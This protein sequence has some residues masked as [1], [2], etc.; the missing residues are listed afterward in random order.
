VAALTIGAACACGDGSGTSGTGGSSGAQPTPSGSTTGAAIDPSQYSRLVYVAA[1][2]SDANPGTIDRPWA[3]AQFAAESATPGTLVYFRAGTYRQGF[4]T[5]RGGSAGAKIAFAAYPGETPIFDGTG[6]DR[7]NGIILAHDHVVL[8]G[9]TVAGWSSTAIWVEHAAQ[10]AI[11]NTVVHD[12]PFGI[13]V[14][15][16]SHDFTISGCEAHHFRGFGYD[17]TCE[18]GSECYNGVF[19][20]CTAHTASD[21]EQNVDGFALG[22]RY[23]RDFRFER[24]TTYGVYDG[25][26][27]S[28]RNTTLDRCVA[29]NCR[30]GGFKLWQSNIVL[31]NCLAH[32]NQQTNVELDW[33]DAVGPTMGTLLANCTFVNASVFNV[34]VENGASELRMD[35]TIVGGGDNIGLC[36]LAGRASAYSGDNNLFHNDN[37]NRM[38]VVFDTDREYATS[39]LAS[40]RADEGEDR[41]STAIASLA[42]AFVNLDGDDYH[43][44][45]GSPAIDAANCSRAPI[46][47]FDGLSRPQGAGCDIGAYERRF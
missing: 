41:L 40:W 45:A 26:D 30:N 24:C 34:V 15:P 17:V 8:H 6:I 33:D 3:T 28:G 11:A 2:G 4:S 7:G 10:F 43:L 23:T 22:H 38:I 39:D 5:A 29:R 16:G 21:P 27:I 19:R 46:F 35:N 42:S 31:N 1:N 37:P 9:L 36:F 20:D 12:V 14:G 32:D 44:A 13:G 47:D 18:A 25:F